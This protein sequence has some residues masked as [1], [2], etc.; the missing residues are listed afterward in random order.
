MTVTDDALQEACAKLGLCPQ[1]VLPVALPPGPLGFAAGHP[2][3]GWAYLRSV[4][5]AM[6]QWCETEEFS[7]LRYDEARVRLRDRTHLRARTKPWDEVLVCVADLGVTITTED[8]AAHTKPEID[9]RYLAWDLL[10]Y[11]G[12]EVCREVFADR[13]DSKLKE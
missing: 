2:S 5:D 4:V 13:F 1:G 7:E 10:S 11:A 12:Y 9:L 3:P 6:E 8:A